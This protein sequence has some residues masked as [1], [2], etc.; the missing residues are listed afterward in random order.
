MATGASLY[1]CRCPKCFYN[2]ALDETTESGTG[3]TVGPAFA[4][5][6]VTISAMPKVEV[7]STATVSSMPALKTEISSYHL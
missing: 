4:E 7:E 2:K 3:S 6:P 5:W 1:F